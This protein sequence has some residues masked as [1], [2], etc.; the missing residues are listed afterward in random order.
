[1]LSVYHRILNA[2]YMPKNIKQS[3]YKYVL[4]YLFLYFSLN[5]KP[6]IASSI[7]IKIEGISGTAKGIRPLIQTR[8]D[9]RNIVG[10]IS[11]LYINGT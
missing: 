3:S 8:I 2:M 9:K 5:D 7:Q 4:Q 6:D 10:G 1:M 11:T